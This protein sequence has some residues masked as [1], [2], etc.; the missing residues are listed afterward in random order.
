LRG[1]FPF[2]RAPSPYLGYKTILPHPHLKTFTKFDCPIVY[3]LL[4]RMQAKHIFY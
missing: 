1:A 3:T 2:L 4:T